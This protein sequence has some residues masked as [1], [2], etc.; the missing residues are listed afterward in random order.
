MRRIAM[1]LPLLFCLA[2][3]CL[4]AEL[5]SPP[6]KQMEVVKRV[7]PDFAKQRRLKQLRDLSLIR[8]VQ[9]A[10]P[11]E[12]AKEENLPELSYGRRVLARIHLEKGLVMLGRPGRVDDFYVELG[13][14]L[15]YPIDYRWGKNEKRDD[16]YAAIAEEFGRACMKEDDK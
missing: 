5:E 3:T 9:Y 16:K 15:F 10:S 8:V 13:K 11:E 6:A 1:F 14:F 2:F 4:C 12:L 7:A